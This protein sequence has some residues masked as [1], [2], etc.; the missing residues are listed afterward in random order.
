V[1]GL[2]STLFESP[3]PGLGRALSAIEGDQ[4]YKYMNLL[5]KW[6]RSHRLIGSTDAEWM[7]EN[8]V[9]DSLAFLQVIPPHISNVAD[10]GSGAGL[11]GIPIA[12]V[13]ADLSMSLIEV[14]QRRVSF[15]ST[16]VRELALASVT[17]L[18]ERAEALGAEHAGRFD[19]VVLRCAGR[20]RAVL[21]EAMRLVRSG[22]C[23]VMSA[24]PGIS[25]PRGGERLVVRT[26][27]DEGTRT[28]H[29]FLKT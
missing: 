29:R 21:P 26:W 5:V 8:V 2:P 25:L 15:L 23:V 18:A 13:R 9:L 1:T 20:S 14:R 28:F 16:V 27:S 17:V 24:G 3:L 6:Q 19:A 11:P 7:L 10:L 4:I 22:G 12:I